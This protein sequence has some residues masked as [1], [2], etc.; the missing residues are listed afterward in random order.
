[1]IT[2]VYSIS[3]RRVE[4]ALEQLRRAADAAERVLDLVREAADQLAVRLLLLV[5]ALLA[6][7]LELAVDVAELD[8]H[9]G[10]VDVD[11]R[12]GARQVQPR[13]AARAELDLLLGV[14]RSARAGLPD[15]GVE[16]GAVAE[17]LR[18][19]ALDELLARQLEQVL[20]G[21]VGPGHAS[22]LGDQQHR[23]REHFEAR[24]GRGR[25]G[26]EERDADHGYARP[27]DATR[28]RGGA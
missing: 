24:A 4:L 11:R 28:V 8:E 25:D 16:R 7:D 15:R 27:R 17:D 18:G 13:L 3:V 19:P 14:G 1:M 21:G 22:V 26:L 20:G 2:C 9:R 6:R 10:V 5:E 12:R 23:R